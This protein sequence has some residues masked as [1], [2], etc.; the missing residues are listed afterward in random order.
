MKQSLKILFAIL[1]ITSITNG[2]SNNKDNETLFTTVFKT[3]KGDVRGINLNSTINEVKEKEGLKPDSISD[4]YLHY[5]IKK[6]DKNTIIDIAY[7]FDKNGLYSADI[8]IKTDSLSAI[9]TLQT[10]TIKLFTKKYGAPIKLAP[11]IYLWNYTSPSGA[12]AS[13]Q[14]IN[15]SNIENKGAL[16]IIVQ[17]E[18][19]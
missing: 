13:A 11:Q 16:E 17:T 7:N 14:L 18:V 1:I 4:N 3:I 15:N 5:T 9:D 8:V 19:E 10:K 2:C 6:N 12:S